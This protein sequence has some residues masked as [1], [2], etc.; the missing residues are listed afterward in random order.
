MTWKHKLVATTIVLSGMSFTPD[1]RAKT[2]RK[3]FADFVSGASTILY[4]GSGSLLPLLT[5]RA[6]GGRHPLRI[7]DNLDTSATLCYGL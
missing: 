5:D 6:D 2:D 1:V 3:G 4:L 7:F